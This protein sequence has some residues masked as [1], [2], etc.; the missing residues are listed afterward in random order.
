MQNEDIK[1][2][3]EDDVAGYVVQRSFTSHNLFD[4]FAV[5]KN[6]DFLF[7]ADAN[8]SFE[9]ASALV[10]AVNREHFPYVPTPTELVEI[11]IQGQQRIFKA[12]K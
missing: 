2:L 9:K 1:R 12:V 5:D 6:G 3:E 10:D 8:L 11:E 7:C 4:V